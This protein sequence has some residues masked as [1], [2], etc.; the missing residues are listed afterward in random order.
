V[1]ATRDGT[2]PKTPPIPAPISPPIPECRADVDVAPVPRVPD[3]PV[4]RGTIG[5]VHLA[6]VTNR[7]SGGGT[8]RDRIL[9]LLSRRGVRLTPL[10]LAD[11]PCPLPT[12][13]DRLVVAGGDG[14][15]GVAARTANTAGVPLAVIPTGT[16]NDF[17]S[18]ARLP[19]DVEA[20]CRLAVAGTRTAHHEVGLT[21][22]IAFVNVAAAGLSAVASTLADP[23]KKR[24]GALA[25]PA[26]AVRAAVTAQPIDCRVLVDGT[27]RFAGKAWQVVVA[28]TGAFG[29]GSS[30]GDTDPG[31]GLLDVATV[32]ATSRLALAKYGYGMR[33]G[34][35]TRLR[36]VRHH[37][38]TRIELTSGEFTVDGEPRTLDPAVFALLPG[39]VDVVAP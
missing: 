16:A 25:Y 30:I 9:R 13:T 11:L 21:G 15:L 5:G 4:V 29:G 24:L 36:A 27:E 38:G 17:A 1:R 8:D 26:S 39:G 31:D 2:T 37:R 35:L 7:H 32:P 28:A 23:L 10:D 12:D 14:S 19:R 3:V 33:L 6:V 20:A 22:D 34:T 18:A